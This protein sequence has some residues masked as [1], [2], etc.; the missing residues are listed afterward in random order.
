[1]YEWFFSE[2]RV[3]YLMK[4]EDEIEFADV[5]EVAVQALHKVMYDF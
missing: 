5:S 3:A 4:V 1:M 2:D